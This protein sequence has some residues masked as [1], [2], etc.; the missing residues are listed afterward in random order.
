MT[1][2]NQTSPEPNWQSEFAEAFFPTRRLPRPQSDLT[3]HFVAVV[4][5]H[6]STD[7][8]RKA[9]CA[10]RYIRRNN[11]AVSTLLTVDEKWMERR[12]AHLKA[13]GSQHQVALPAFYRKTICLPTS[14]ASCSVLINEIALARVALN[15]QSGY[16]PD[17]LATV[18]GPAEKLTLA[19]GGDPVLLHHLD[20]ETSM[21]RFFSEHSVKRVISLDRRLRGKLVIAVLP[22]VGTVPGFGQTLR[23]KEAFRHV[24]QSPI[25]GLLEVSS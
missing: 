17:F 10:F 1:D 9:L 4:G 8:T 6:R 2:R 23:H 21:E 18:I 25:M 19:L 7:E 20:A 13:T 12:L 22:P 15:K 16:T 3:E 5:S 14:P 24:V 11:D